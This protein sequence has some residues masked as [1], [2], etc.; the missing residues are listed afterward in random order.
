MSAKFTPKLP[1]TATCLGYPRW[2]YTQSFILFRP[3]HQGNKA[4]TAVVA[5]LGIC[6]MFMMNMSLKIPVKISQSVGLSVI[7]LFSKLYLWRQSLSRNCPWQWQVLAT[8]SEATHRALSYFVPITKVTRLGQPLLLSR[9]YVTCLRWIWV[10]KCQS[11]YARVL[12]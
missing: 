5:L 10:L 1:A 11:K 12:V 3:H 8:L 2:S 6:D 7:S 4:R 9:A